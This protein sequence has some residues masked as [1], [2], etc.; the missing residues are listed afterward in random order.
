MKCPDGNT[1]VVLQGKSR[2][3][4][5]RKLADKPY[6]RAKVESLS[7]VEPPAGNKEFK[8]LVDSLKD[9]TLKIIKF[10]GGMPPE[11]SFAVKN[12]ENSNFLINFIS[13]NSKI[14]VKE[15]QHLLETDELLKRAKDLLGYLS[16]EVQVLETEK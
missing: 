16:R 12:I 8:P 5:V 11:A 7:E 3:K 1:T 4:V 6:F 10:S 15:K 14:P 2:F 13:S 9:L